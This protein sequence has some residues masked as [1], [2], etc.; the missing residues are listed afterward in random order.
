MPDTSF[1]AP[2]WCVTPAD[3]AYPPALLDPRVRGPDALHLRGVLPWPAGRRVAIVGARAILPYARRATRRIVAALAPAGAVVVSGVAR[4]V[5]G[6]AHRAALARGGFTLGVLGVGID[7]VYPPEHAS[8]YTA[9]AAHGCLVSAWGPGE[10]V[11]RGRFPTRNRVLAALA[12]DVVLV[13]ADVTSGSRH[14]VAAALALGRRVWIVP[15]P[16]GHAAYAGNAAWAA[17]GGATLRVLTRAAEPLSSRVPGPAAPPE[18]TGVGTATAREASV[19]ER[20]RGVLAARP[21]SVDAIARAAHAAA[22]ETAAALI[23]LEWTGEA[24]RAPGD[25]FRRRIE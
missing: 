15:W 16:L 14:T 21:R 22:G 17:R 7:Q 3:P 19:L 2:T 23:E 5:D 1:G 13:Q 9:I 4:G 24:A 18:A 6:C 12:D 20:V 10:G 11:R 8:L 25:R